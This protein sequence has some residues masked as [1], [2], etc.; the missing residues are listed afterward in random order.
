M[1]INGVSWHNIC[2]RIVV[3][4]SRPKSPAPNFC[5]SPPLM[6]RDKYLLIL[7]AF[8]HE[9]HT[10]CLSI[11]KIIFQVNKVFVITVEYKTM[12]IHHYKVIQLSFN[13]TAAVSTNRFIVF[14]F[15]LRLSCAEVAAM[16]VLV[17][18]WLRR[19]SSLSSLTQNCFNYF[20]DLENDLVLDK[21]H[22]WW[23]NSDGI[24]MCVSLCTRC[25]GH[26]P[27]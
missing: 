25:C 23:H 2:M 21:H 4:R 16:L 11:S 19:C 20:I 7:F 9:S 8:C 27:Q 17:M 13:I 3:G 26:F 5:P 15:L 18:C 24:E 6:K 22:V 1:Y 10:T 12:K 14:S